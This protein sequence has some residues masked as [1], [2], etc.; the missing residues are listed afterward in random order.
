MR[1]LVLVSLLVTCFV[2]AASQE[3]SAQTRAQELAASFSK[4]KSATKEKNGVRIEKYKD[5]RSEAVVKQNPGD[6]SGVYELVDLG[7]VLNL[8]VG[9]DGR[10]K[11]DGFEATGA[12]SQPR[13]FR[14]E[15][16]KVDG[17]LLTATKVYN[18]GS[19]SKFEGVFITRTERKSPTDI[20]SSTFGLG[21]VLT[22]P[23][24]HDGLTYE[25]VFYQLK[26]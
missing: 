24:E 26:R 5:V 7:Y 16:A 1:S 13:T 23:F 19:A 3:L 8:Q 20:G 25:K 9:N 11:A 14:L 15:N 2:V 22:T 6:Y 18:D 21:V 17:A 12:N 10:V 4:H